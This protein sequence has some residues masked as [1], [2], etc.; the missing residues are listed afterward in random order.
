M[1]AIDATAGPATIDSTPHF[2]HRCV[3]TALIDAPREL[4]EQSLHAVEAWPRHL[5]HVLEIDVK[6]DDGQYQEFIM[7]VASDTDGKPLR[8][9]SI[10]NCREHEIEF[11][12]PEPPPFLRHHGGIWRFE[13]SDG[14]CSVTVTHVWNLDEAQA[15]RIYP[16]TE[17]AT[18]ADQVERM[19]ANH[20]RLAL[21]TWTA[22]LEASPTEAVI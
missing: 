16:A 7:V 4:V 19:L 11:F 1:A 18:T 6:Y 3:Q 8:V 20:S 5:P 17:A 9:R 21:E 14:G 13:D 10:R 2:E 15:A 22:I 12:Q